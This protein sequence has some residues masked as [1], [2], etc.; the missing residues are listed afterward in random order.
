MRTAG[1]KIKFLLLLTIVGVLIGLSSAG[2]WY[3]RR[4]K[5][6]W[7]EQMSPAQSLLLRWQ[8]V[9]CRALADECAE[10]LESLLSVHRELL[11]TLPKSE[12]AGPYFGLARKYFAEGKYSESF[13]MYCRGLSTADRSEPSDPF[14]VYYAALAGELDWLDAQLSSNATTCP[15]WAW[16][17]ILARTA[18]E[19]TKGHYAV[20]LEVSSSQHVES[21]PRS[22]E[23]P[24]W[25]L[26]LRLIRA[27]C[28]AERGSYEDAWAELFT[29]VQA[30][31]EGPI[32]ILIHYLTEAAKISEEAG[33]YSDAL[34]LAQ[35]ALEGMRAFVE[36]SWN[37]PA[38]EMEQL[39]ARAERAVGV[40]E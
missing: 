10:Q 33:K 4:H 21:L 31:A 30:K 1:K 2:L 16:R 28:L 22:P 9:T 13:G 5:A 8:A 29:P 18:C 20:A 24:D 34:R 23:G 27:R 36:P 39:V 26:W 40:E 3:W 6:I 19:W 15:A 35:K 12:Q 32:W 17:P 14:F 38:Q 25:E 11:S 37:I 7:G